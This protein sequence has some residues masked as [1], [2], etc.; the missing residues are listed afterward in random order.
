MSEEFNLVLAI[1]SMV[2][3]ILLSL[4]LSATS[5]ESKKNRRGKLIVLMSAG[6]VSTIFITLSLVR[7]I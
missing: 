4:E 5:K 1:V 2:I 6:I 7:S 3:W